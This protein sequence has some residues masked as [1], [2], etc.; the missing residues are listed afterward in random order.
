LDLI[1][2]GANEANED[3]CMNMLEEIKVGGSN[4]NNSH[5]NNSSS[6]SNN[7]NNNIK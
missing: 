4:N 7:S 6:N 5:N 1:R 2:F 3:I